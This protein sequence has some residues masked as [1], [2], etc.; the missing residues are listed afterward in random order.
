MIAL[1]YFFKQRPKEIN[2]VDWRRHSAFIHLFPLS[3]LMEAALFCLCLN[4]SSILLPGFSESSTETGVMWWQRWN[5]T[6]VQRR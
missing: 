5:A 1:R 6:G 3:A 2:S 4:C